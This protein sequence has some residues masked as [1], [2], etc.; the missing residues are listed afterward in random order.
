MY[1]L[2]Q[3]QRLMVGYFEIQ[4]ERKKY[5]KTKTVFKQIRRFI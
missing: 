3:M 5:S 2:I 1:F 4:T